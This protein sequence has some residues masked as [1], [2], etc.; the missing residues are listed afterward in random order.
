MKQNLEFSNLSVTL[1]SPCST[2]VLK[3]L[4]VPDQ[5]QSQH[6]CAYCE[7]HVSLPCSGRSWTTSAF[8]PSK[9]R[10]SGCLRSM[11]AIGSCTMLAKIAWHSGFGTKP[12]HALLFLA[13]GGILAMAH[14]S[15]VC[16]CNMHGKCTVP[17]P[18]VTPAGIIILIFFARGAFSGTYHKLIE[19]L[20]GRDLWGSPC[21]SIASTCSGQP[22][23]F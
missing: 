23:F 12:W 1:R 9:R 17:T 19:T 4:H 3:T 16:A 13:S 10:E 21:S 8:D 5:A 22:C 7:K 6:Q 11:P 15:L 14:F 18:R 2:S 20:V